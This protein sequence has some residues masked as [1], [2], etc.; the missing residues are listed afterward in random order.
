MVHCTLRLRLRGCCWL[1]APLVPTCKEDREVSTT[2]TGSWGWTHSLIMSTLAGTLLSQVG[3][4]FDN[5]H[6][7]VVPCT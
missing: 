5:W 3:E 6:M 1:G 4:D 7:S 2:K